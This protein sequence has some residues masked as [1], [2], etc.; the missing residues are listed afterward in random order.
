MINEYNGSNLIDNGLIYFYSSW[1]STCNMYNDLINIIDKK[2]RNL[3][4]MKVNTTKHYDMKEEF[5]VKKIPSFVLVKNNEIISRI[6]GTTS[7]YTMINWIND[8]R[9]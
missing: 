6:D 7:Q 5:E 1:I 3:S 4:I 9:G 8:N 2:F